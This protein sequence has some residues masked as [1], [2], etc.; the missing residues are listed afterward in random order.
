MR[1]LGGGTALLLIWNPI[2]TAKPNKCSHFVLVQRCLSHLQ[3]LDGA[4]MQSYKQNVILARVLNPQAQTW[5][6]QA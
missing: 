6:Q 2:N 4:D 1:R 3:H 5:G